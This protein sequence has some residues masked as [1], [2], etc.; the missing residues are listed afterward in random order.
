VALWAWI[1]NQPEVH[2][3]GKDVR[4]FLEECERITMARLRAGFDR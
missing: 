3:R 1:G 4:A 2:M